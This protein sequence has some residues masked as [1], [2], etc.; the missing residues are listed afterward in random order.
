MVLQGTVRAAFMIWIP[1]F[2]SKFA[3]EMES[4]AL[5]AYSSA[6]PPPATMP[7]STAAR[8]ALR[9]SVTRSFFSET[10][11]SVAPPTLM[12]ATPP[13]SLA[14]RSCN[15]SFSYSEVV[16][17]MVSRSSSHLSSMAVFSPA[18]SRMMVSSL[19]MVTFLAVP[20]AESSAVSSFMPVSSEMTRPLV[21]TA[22]SCSVALRLSPKPGALTAAT[23][24][25]P[26]SL[27]T[28]SVASASPS[29]SSAMMTSGFCILTTCSRRGSML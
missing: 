4:S 16:V 29:T 20:S 10:S 17:E 7:S 15:F 1:C 2:W 3:A 27:F 12:T 11:V 13:D 26:R 6:A 9:A 21:N 28:T 14:S 25:P 19:E 5:V 8:V 23:F 18:P 22:M 24:T